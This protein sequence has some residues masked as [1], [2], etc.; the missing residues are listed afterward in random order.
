M[1]KP[2]RQILLLQARKSNSLLVWL[3][4]FRVVALVAADEDPPEGVLDKI[5]DDHVDEENKDIFWFAFLIGGIG[6]VILVVRLVFYR[7]ILF[8][9]E[10]KANSF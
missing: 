4:I 10:F 7:Y 8:L 6:T 2:Y 3:W 5:A 1:M 9:K